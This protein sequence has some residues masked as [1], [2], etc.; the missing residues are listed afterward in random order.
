[1]KKIKKNKYI[2]KQIKV[3]PIK[4][5]KQK[6]TYINFWLLVNQS[7]WNCVIFTDT[8][9]NVHKPCRAYNSSEKF[10]CFIFFQNISKFANSLFSLSTVAN[11]LGARQA[12]DSITC[13]AY[14]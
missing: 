5:K 3:Y 4:K 11:I 6:K 12:R 1:M 2:H 7:S 13:F 14:E 10:F 8:P 9:N